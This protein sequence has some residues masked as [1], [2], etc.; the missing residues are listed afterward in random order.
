MTAGLEALDAVASAKL[1]RD[2]ECP[3]RELVEAAIAR[4]E[5]GN[6][7][8]NAVVHTRFE[9]ALAEADV[10]DRSAPFA[11]VPF[12]YKD[13]GA[14]EEGD[15]WTCGMRLLR[16]RGF[17]APF[18]SHYAERIR[19][20]GFIPLGRTNTPELALCATTEPA[21][22]GPTRNPWDVERTPGGSSG[23]SAAAV[24]AGFVPVAHAN[25]GGGSIRIPAAAC[26]LV[27]LKPS[28]GRVSWGPVFWEPDA[29][30]AV[31]G[32]VSRSV[33]DSAALLDVLAGAHPGDPY[34]A[35]PAAGPW[36][37]EA[38]ADP[39]RLR[40][41]VLDEAPTGA[42]PTDP[43]CADAIRRVAAALE[44]LGHA[45]ELSAPELV[46]S[47][48]VATGFADWWAVAIAGTIPAFEEALGTRISRDDVE[49]FTWALIERGRA[50]SGP[51]FVALRDRLGTL[52]RF[53]A[54]WWA[55][56]YDLLLTPTLQTVPPPLGELM[57]GD[58]RGV[59]DR[60]LRWFP[61]TPFANVSGQPAISV[62]VDPSE[63][64][65]L[66]VGAHLMA[67]Y[68]REDVLIRVAAQLEEALPW[69]GFAPT[70]TTEAASPAS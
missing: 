1:V 45:V 25:D 20:A 52:A 58:P 12:L 66:P 9:A 49:P 26:G 67:P 2:G 18:G 21:A 47:G 43:R 30:L 57:R 24:A 69:R 42:Q 50:L 53:A 68:G 51:Q 35:P 54:A 64:H 44:A 59:L 46:T 10:V 15:A 17:V 38:G 62:P 14:M 22:F 5:A 34:V 8:I 37:Q 4:I 55:Q 40:I 36:A 3:P 63:D 70:A 56:G 39:G 41:G 11:G 61:V 29:G 28:R 32:V 33:R 7:R 27:G 65:D 6:E 13:I 31:E 19:A 48:Q 23:G 16:D 60:Q